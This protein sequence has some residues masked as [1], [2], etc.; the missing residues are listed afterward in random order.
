M[1]EPIAKL[2]D[3]YFEEIACLETALDLKSFE[4]KYKKLNTL[5]KEYIDELHIVIPELSYFKGDAVSLYGKKYS[6]VGA[7][8]LMGAISYLLIL[9]GREVAYQLFTIN[10]P[11]DDK[12][13]F[14]DQSDNLN[15]GDYTFKGL[16]NFASIVKQSEHAIILYTGLIASIGETEQIRSKYNTN[17]NQEAYVYRDILVDLLNQNPS[18]MITFIHFDKITQTQIIN[19]LTSLCRNTNFIDFSCSSQMMFHTYNSNYDIK[20]FRFLMDTLTLT[21]I[22]QRLIEKIGLLWKNLYKDKT[23]E[24]QKFLD[25]FENYIDECLAWVHI[26]LSD[27]DFSTKFLLA[28]GLY[29]INARNCEES[30]IIWLALIELDDR[31]LDILKCNVTNSMTDITFLNGEDQLLL[32][33]VN[34]FDNF[35]NKIKSVVV[36][37]NLIAD[38]IS[39][40][41]VISVNQE[42]ILQVDI[43]EFVNKIKENKISSVH[44]LKIYDEIQKNKKSFSAAL[45]EVCGTSATL[46]ESFNGLSLICQGEALLSYQKLH[47]QIDK[48]NPFIEEPIEEVELSTKEERTRY[49]NN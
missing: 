23:S 8:A 9:S 6:E 44:I 18:L 24:N 16:S 49:G 46:L 1:L 10:Q 40:N 42:K 2:L 14:G 12:L 5:L 27:I 45:Q 33:L 26:K 38:A 31:I 43:T 15:K 7:T 29:A 39:Q 17:S 35:D 3:K 28:K 37:Y 20:S 36:G 41:N 11:Q 34:K 22:D 13:K 48:N 19:V 25:F 4:Q 21:S 32:S 47:N 30:Q